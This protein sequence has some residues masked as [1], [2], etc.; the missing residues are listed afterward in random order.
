MR[1]IKNILI[2]LFASIIVFSNTQLPIITSDYVVTIEAHSGRTDSRGGHKD[3]KNKSGLGRYHY[4]CGGHP[5]HLHPNGVCPYDGVPASNT[6]SSSSES[7]TVP[8][9]NINSEQLNKQ[10]TENALLNK[11]KAVLDEFENKRGK[12]FTIQVSQMINDFIESP[13]M[14][15]DILAGF[16]TED[17]RADLYP[18]V[19]QVQTDIAS[20]ILYMRLYEIFKNQYETQQ[21]QIVAQQQAQQIQQTQDEILYIIVIQTQTQLATLGF[22]TGT[23]DGIFDIETQQS[24]INFQTT[25]GLIVDGTINQQVVLTLGITI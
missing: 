11:Y 6:S 17:E 5:A 21:A 16:L 18:D 24:L 13:G 15:D 25:Y 10:N 4:H 2:A 12:Y 14:S 22:Y 20:K 23:I 3:N 8:S 9:N 7:N 19:S 1:K